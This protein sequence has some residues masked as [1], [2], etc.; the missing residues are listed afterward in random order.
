[1]KRFGSGVCAF[2][3]TYANALKKR[4]GKLGDKWHLDEV[5]LTH[6]R[7]DPLP[8]EGRRPEW[9]RAGYPR[10]EPTQ[11]ACK[12]L[13]KESDFCYHTTLEI[14]ELIPYIPSDFTYCNGCLRIG[15]G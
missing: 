11:Q 4:R 6:Q 5:F 10:A 13:Y 1:M 15:Y 7:E 14:D 9:Q 3:Q 12:D 2:G 8:L